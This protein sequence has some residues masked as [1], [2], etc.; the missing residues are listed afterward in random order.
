MIGVRPLCLRQWPLGVESGGYWVHRANGGRLSLNPQVNPYGYITF[1]VIKYL[2]ARLPAGHIPTGE[3]R[4]LFYGIKP[5][6]LGQVFGVMSRW[7]D[8]A[9]NGSC[10]ARRK[11]CHSYEPATTPLRFWP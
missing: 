11:R 5:T 6:N 10:V 4:S 3:T 7:G 8:S 2:P 9:P 1:Y